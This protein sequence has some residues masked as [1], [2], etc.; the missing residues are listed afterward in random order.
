LASGLALL[1]LVFML[2]YISQARS[3]SDENLKK[4]VAVLIASH[5][6]TAGTLGSSL[7]TG[8][9]V[10][11]RVPQS[12]AVPESIKTPGALRGEIVTQDI[13]SGEQVSLRKFGPLQA[14][15][16]RVKIHGHDRVVELTGEKEQ[17]LDGTL[18]TGDHVDMLATW[19]VPESCG[20]CHVSRII[21]RDALVLAT[22]AEL[23]AGTSGSAPVQ[24][25]LTD[26]QAE[27]VFWMQRNGE[28]TL[29]VRPVVKPKSSK[30]GFDNSISILKSS[31][32][33]K[34]ESR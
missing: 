24:L 9:F 31:L 17:V 8:A 30:Q 32:V 2:I 19:N 4:S 29:L 26:A 16:V 21:V 5:D 14:A 12:V 34:G 23:G 13:L 15:G 25:R 7:Q 22:S 18:K 10:E 3:S 28:W 33:R 27:R 6:I 20:Q 1:A 11:K